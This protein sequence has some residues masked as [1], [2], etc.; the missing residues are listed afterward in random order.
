MAANINMN[1]ARVT[2]GQN[3][4]RKLKKKNVAYLRGDEE[5]PPQIEAPGP[6]RNYSTADR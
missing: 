5:E 1:L 4:F 6:N 3:K 2:M